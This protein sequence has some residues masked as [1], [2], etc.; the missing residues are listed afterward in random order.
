MSDGTL[1][2]PNAATAPSVL[3]TATDEVVTTID[4]T[5]TWAGRRARRTGVNQ[6]GD[7]ARSL[8]LEGDVITVLALYP[9]TSGH[10]RVHRRLAAFDIPPRS[11]RTR[12]TASG[13]RSAMK[14][15]SIG[16]TSAVIVATCRSPS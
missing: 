11:W 4:G 1:W 8:V 7:Q 13:C 10:V 16:F 3:D 5:T 14:L 12:K 6:P 9:C 15:P 2:C